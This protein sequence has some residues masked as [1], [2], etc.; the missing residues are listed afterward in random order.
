MI[1][2][3]TDYQRSQLETLIEILCEQNKII[4]AIFIMMPLILRE[5]RHGLV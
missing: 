5:V 2:K 4:I 1:E 3:L